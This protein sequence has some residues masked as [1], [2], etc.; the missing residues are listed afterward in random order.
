MNFMKKF[1]LGIGIGIIFVFLLM[2]FTAEE[3]QSTEEKKEEKIVETKK[4]EPRY[5]SKLVSFKD[6]KGNDIVQEEVE[7]KEPKKRYRIKEDEKVFLTFELRMDGTKDE[8]PLGRN[9]NVDAYRALVDADGFYTSFMEDA[10]YDE[11]TGH[12][13]FWLTYRYSPYV[14]PGE[15]HFQMSL[16]SSEAEVRNLD[17]SYTYYFI[18][19]DD[20]YEEP[21]VTI[22]S[23]SVIE[24][25]IKPSEAP[26][27]EPEDVIIT[28]G[29][30][31]DWDH[32]LDDW[33]IEEAKWEDAYYE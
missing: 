22:E 8:R 24:E 9:I 6:S 3:D 26:K 20:I 32:I 15:G 25:L 1:F 5:T 33:E 31:E 19:S 7:T 13:S 30:V 23:S 4:V 2:L 29:N 16:M 12:F 17:S 14:T 21:E 27:I 10:V 18:D 28:E 11:T